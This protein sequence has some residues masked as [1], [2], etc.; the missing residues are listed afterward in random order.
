MASLTRYV[1]VPGDLESLTYP[2]L[3]REIVLDDVVVS[4]IKAT[5]SELEVSDKEIGS[6]FLRVYV[7][8][9]TAIMEKIS[10]VEKLTDISHNDLVLIRL[11]TTACLDMIDVQSFDL[12]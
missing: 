2:K 5:F 9:V 3:V 4:T 6:E 12:D 7:D 1:I 11:A 10:S 8:Y